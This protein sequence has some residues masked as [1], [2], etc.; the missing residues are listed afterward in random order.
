MGSKQ[1]QT[2]SS[3]SQQS[4]FN[5]QQNQ[6]DPVFRRNYMQ[7]AGAYNTNLNTLLANPYNPEFSSTPNAITQNMISRGIQGIKD[8]SAGAARSMSLGLNSAGGDNSAPASVL[9]RQAQISNAGAANALT[10]QGLEF[11]RAQDL[12]RIQAEMGAR[13]QQL[14]TLQSSL[15]LLQSY[16]QM[17]Q[18][19]SRQTQ[20]YGQNTS[21]QGS[22]MTRRS[23]F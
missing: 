9:N 16:A 6:L 21:S 17:A 2:Q 7:T 14:E 5:T 1:R 19:A 13:G 20:R 8:Q 23:F 10:G 11:Q 4:G 22:G 12:A 3:Q 18:A 15:P